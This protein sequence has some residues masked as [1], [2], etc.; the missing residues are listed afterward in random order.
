MAGFWARQHPREF[1]LLTVP[2]SFHVPSQVMLK[3]FLR[4][5]RKTAHRLLGN[6]IV[7][8]HLGHRHGAEGLELAA[9]ALHG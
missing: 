7:A 8:H 5:L 4:E 3:P 2:F 9:V 6:L 1:G